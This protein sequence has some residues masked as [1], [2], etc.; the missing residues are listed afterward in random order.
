M[1]EWNRHHIHF[2]QRVHEAQIHT[3]KIRENTWL[4][5]LIRYDVH[6]ELHR[7]ISMVPPLDRFT[8]SYVYKDFIPV[9]D[10]FLKSIDA[11]LFSTKAGLAHPKTTELEKRN[12]E[13]YMFAIEQQIPFIKDG[14]RKARRFYN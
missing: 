12:G 10:N 13:N 2:P 3:K 14:I 6:Q 7:S 11:L 8:A 5:P 4:M 9:R 1:A